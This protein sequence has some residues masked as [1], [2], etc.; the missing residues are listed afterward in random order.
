MDLE[1]AIKLHVDNERKDIRPTKHP[2]IDLRAEVHI[3]VFESA[4]RNSCALKAFLERKKKEL[5]RA[6][7]VDMREDLYAEVQVCERPLGMLR[8]CENGETLDGLA[9]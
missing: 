8:A 1:G 5:G 2:V 9:Y 4:P 6:K 7:S 3:R